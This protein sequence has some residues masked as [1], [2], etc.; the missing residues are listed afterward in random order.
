MY[1]GTENV[2]PSGLRLRAAPGGEHVDANGSV[3]CPTCVSLKAGRIRTQKCRG[4]CGSVGPLFKPAH[5]ERTQSKVTDKTTDT[6]V[7]A[8]FSGSLEAIS[9]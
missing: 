5:V 9:A 8:L 3:F 4:P 2:V 6:R 7:A 1:F